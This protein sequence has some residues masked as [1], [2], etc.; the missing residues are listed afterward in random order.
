MKLILIYSR[1]FRGSH[2]KFQLQ[3]VQYNCS[4]QFDLHAE[5]SL[6]SVLKLQILTRISPTIS[7]L[8]AQG[9]DDTKATEIDV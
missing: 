7:C 9:R 2:R 1:L 4:T 6:H 3:C 8:F 5:V